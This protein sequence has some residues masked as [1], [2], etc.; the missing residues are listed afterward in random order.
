VRLGFG[1]AAGERIIWRRDSRLLSI[2]IR[3]WRI[4]AAKVRAVLAEKSVSRLVLASYL[5]RKFAIFLKKFAQNNGKFAP[6][7]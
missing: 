2:A 5:W 6:Q 3:P 4:G 1:G 7:V